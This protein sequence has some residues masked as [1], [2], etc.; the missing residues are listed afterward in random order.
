[1]GMAGLGFS[2][3]IKTNDMRAR[4]FQENERFFVKTWA[5]EQCFFREWTFCWQNM[6]WK[7]WFFLEKS[8]KKSILLTFL[9][10]N[11]VYFWQNSRFLEQIWAWQMG[12]FLEKIEKN[13]M[14]AQ[15]FWGSGRIFE[16]YERESIV[17]LKNGRYFWQ[18]K[19][20]R[21]VYFSWKIEKKGIPLTFLAQ[22]IV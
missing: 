13:G 8:E 22:N 4:C 10:H 16:K 15:C 14:R 3:E 9:A 7:L 19:G 20:M 18:Y 2:W 5:L 21:T 12:D 1:M 17:F 11:I 6:G